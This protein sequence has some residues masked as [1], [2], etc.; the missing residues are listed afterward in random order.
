MRYAKVIGLLTG[1]VAL[2]AQVQDP[3]LAARHAYNE[4]HYD[5]AIELATTAQSV[6]SAANAAAVI[7]ARAHLERYRQRFDAADLAAARD[8]LKIVDASRLSARDTA[9]LSIGLGEALYLE[10]ESEMLDDRYGAAAELFQ[11]AMKQS[12]V[13]EPETRPV[14]FEWWANALDR[15]AQRGGPETDRKPIYQRLLTGA[16]QELV[17]DPASAAATFWLAAAARGTGDL[18]RAIAAAAAGW[19]SAPRFGGASGK[20]RD[21]LD[22]LVRFTILPER[23]MKLTPEGD[24]RPTFKRLTEQWEETKKRWQ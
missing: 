21:D 17:R 24:P 22:Q 10:G 2:M 14:L 13:L 8:L 5:D 23:A 9:E 20:L 12:S 3:L 15:Q 16:E 19:I 18:D 4:A 1:L 11:T 7:L 6:P